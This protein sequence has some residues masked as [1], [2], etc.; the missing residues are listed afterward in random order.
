MSFA[1]NR[2]M[3]A[4]AGTSGREGST[5]ELSQPEAPAFAGATDGFTLVEALVALLVLGIAAAGL[6]TAADAHVDRVRGL[7]LRAMAGL[8]AQN[9]AVELTLPGESEGTR[10]VEFYGRRWS[11]TAAARP[12]GDPDLLAY[13]VTVAEVGTASVLASLDAFAERQPQ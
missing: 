2:V 3:P 7:E 10:Q 13:R 9:R 12:V 6:L 4:Q 1:L 11:V 5:A 8:V